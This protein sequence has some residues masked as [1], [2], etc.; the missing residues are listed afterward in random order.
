MFL[1]SL[2]L[3]VN[4]NFFKLEIQVFQDGLPKIFHWLHLIP[5]DFL[6][7]YENFCWLKKLALLVLPSSH[8][9]EK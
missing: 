8:E 9:C 1:H 5:F 3:I 6:Q 7:C 4:R 2:N